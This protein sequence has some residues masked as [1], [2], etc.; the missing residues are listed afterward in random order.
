MKTS[1][2]YKD[3]FNNKYDKALSDN[4][5]SIN[6]NNVSKKTINLINGMKNNK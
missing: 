5:L 1:N 3:I 6:S 4:N 2:S